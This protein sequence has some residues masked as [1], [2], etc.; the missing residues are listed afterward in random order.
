YSII[1]RL[2]A[3]GLDAH[4]SI[5]QTARNV[6]GSFIN[7]NG[8]SGVWRKACIV[9][10]G[11]WSADTLTEDLDLS[12]RAQLRGWK[13]TYLENVVTPGELPVLMPAVKLQQYRWNKGGAETARKIAPKILQSQL[14]PQQKMH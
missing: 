8:T 13:F 11:G 1:T 4:F 14:S 12:Y 10:A 5:E 9:D 6:A 7:F 3:F 2:Q